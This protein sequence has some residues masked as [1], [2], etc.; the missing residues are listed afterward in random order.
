M[1]QTESDQRKFLYTIFT[2]HSR[3]V[4]GINGKN[5]KN[6]GEEF[7]LIINRSPWVQ[8]P[9][10]NQ[11]LIQSHSYSERNVRDEEVVEEICFITQEICLLHFIN[12]LCVSYMPQL[13]MFVC[14]RGQQIECLRSVRKSLTHHSKYTLETITEKAPCLVFRQRT[15]TC[16]ESGTT[17]IILICNLDT[18]GAGEDDSI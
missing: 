13:C 10:C 5:G 1:S 12:I 15:H 16:H 6:G 4:S 3:N 14:R 9:P 8:I 7:S 2:I 17:I 11:T 18:A